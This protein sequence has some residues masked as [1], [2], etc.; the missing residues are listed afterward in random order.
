MADS[1][2]SSL[3]IMRP[4]FLLLAALAYVA[5]ALPVG[6]RDVVDIEARSNVKGDGPTPA[7]PERPP[8]P[9]PATVYNPD[10]QPKGKTKAKSK[11]SVKKR[12]LYWDIEARSNV[13][14]DGPTP[15]PP[16]RP[17]SPL[18]AT[19]YNPDE[20]PKGKT[21]VK[22]KGSVKKRE[23]YWEDIEARSNVKGD[24]PTPAPPERPPSPLPATVYNPDEQPKGKTK[25]KSKGS[26]KKRELYWE[27]IHA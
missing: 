27:A 2:L 24:G 15:A 8:S 16:E 21:K 5:V 6:K 4:N 12:E 9:L 23:L 10:E 7:P 26:V 1:W 20:Q 22:S 17:P 11:G 13:K 25:A 3:F 14:G 18:P 19:V